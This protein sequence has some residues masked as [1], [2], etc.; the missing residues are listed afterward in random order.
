MYR[1]TRLRSP[2]SVNFHHP[3]RSKN[4]IVSFSLWFIPNLATIIQTFRQLLVKGAI[5]N[6]NAT[7][8]KSILELKQLVQSAIELV[9]PNF[10][11]LF[12]L[13]ANASNFHLGVVQLQQHPKRTWRPIA[14]ISCA[15]TT[16]K[17]YYS[18]TRK[19]FLAIVWAF[20]KFHPYLQGTT[21]TIKEIISR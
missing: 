15:L 1:W 8:L 11:K 5:F 17:K 10:A 4:Y 21:V 12:L 14:Y 20:N 2:P 19:K 18:T 13:E 16:A 3:R 9:R 7:C 6:W